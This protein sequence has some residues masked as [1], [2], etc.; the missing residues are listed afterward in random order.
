LLTTYQKALEYVAHPSLI[1]DFADDIITALVRH[2]PDGDYSLA[3]SYFNTVQPVLKTSHALELLFDAMARTNV[4]ESLYYSRTHPENI[5]Q[6]LFQLLIS[7]VLDAP[8]S[9]EKSSRAL[10]LVGLPFD[11]LEEVWFEEFLTQ[12]NGRNLK[13]SKDTLVMR[14]LVTGHYSDATRVKGLGGHWGTVLEN[15]KSGMGS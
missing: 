11:N 6:L 15:V 3:L 10:E 14:K 9:D 7:N 5:R 8:G 4:T 1:P 12:G 2:A 13:K